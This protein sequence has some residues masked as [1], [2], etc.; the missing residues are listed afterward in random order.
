[1]AVETTHL[2][3]TESTHLPHQPGH[4]LVILTAATRVVEL[5]LL[6]VVVGQIEHDGAS[7]KDTHVAIFEGRDAPVGIDGEEPVFLL[8]VFGDI[9][10]F[11][12][13]VEA[14]LLQDD[15]WLQA[16]GRAES[17]VGEIVEWRIA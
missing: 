5:A 17:V 7:F 16:I 14:E 2:H 11:L 1:M 4:D 12:L 3:R 9:D 10:R 6:V 8:G 15:V 13:V